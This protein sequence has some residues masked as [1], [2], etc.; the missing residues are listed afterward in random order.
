MTGLAA[1]VAPVLNGARNLPKNM[2]KKRW[3]KNS[4][5]LHRYSGWAP[6]RLNADGDIETVAVDAGM[7]G[8]DCPCWQLG[9]HTPQD[10]KMPLTYCLCCAG[11]F[12]FH[13]QKSLGLKLRVKHVASSIL[14]SGGNKPCVFVYEIVK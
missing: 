3:R 10:E 5:C 13:Y 9:G 11:H 14:H 7:D 2:P 4:S 8:N 6:P 1:R 12:R